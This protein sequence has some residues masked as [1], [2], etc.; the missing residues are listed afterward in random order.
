MV[1]TSYYPGVEL[2]IFDIA[3][4][5]SILYLELNYLE[6]F[7]CTLLIDKVTLFYAGSVY[8]DHFV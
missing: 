4:F 3:N 5:C 6:N 7:F 2:K 1:I 8:C